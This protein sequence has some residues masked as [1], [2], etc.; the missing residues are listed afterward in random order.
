MG[1]SVKFKM[2]DRRQYYG[3]WSAVTGPCAWCQNMF[4]DGESKD[5][6]GCPRE[7]ADLS[8]AFLGVW[9]IKPQISEH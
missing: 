2:P 5:L 1:Q 4:R 8:H 6:L 7:L 3:P 9:K